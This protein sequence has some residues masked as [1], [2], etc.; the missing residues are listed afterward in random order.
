MLDPAYVS[1]RRTSLVT[2]FL[3]NCLVAI[4]FELTQTF[5]WPHELPDASQPENDELDLTV[6]GH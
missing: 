4:H 6:F 3:V 5:V 2:V 1:Q